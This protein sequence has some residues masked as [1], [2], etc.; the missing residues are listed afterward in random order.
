MIHQKKRDKKDT[1]FLAEGG[2]LVT[3]DTAHVIIAS[4]AKQSKKC[5][6]EIASSHKALR[7]MTVW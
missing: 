1:R 5:N 6:S 4:G 7:A 2:N 3:S